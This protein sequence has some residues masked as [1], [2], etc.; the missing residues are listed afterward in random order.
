[1]DSHCLDSNPK[2]ILYL[3]SLEMHMPAIATHI[4]LSFC[5]I[6]QSETGQAEVL[7][8]H[9]HQMKKEKD[10]FSSLKK[11]TKQMRGIIS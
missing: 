9:N 2:I 10:N 5:G 4:G 1:M 6:K 7:P 11:V 8:P 3:E